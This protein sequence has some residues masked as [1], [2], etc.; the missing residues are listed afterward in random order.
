M[1]LFLENI[2]LKP[3]L[4]WVG[5][6]TQLLKVLTALLPNEPIINYCEPFFGGGAML[7]NIKPFVAF[8]N[9]SNKEL[10][11][12]YNIIKTCPRE[13]IT[14]LSKYENTPEFYY[15]IRSVDRNINEFQ[16]LSPIQRA[17]RFIYLNKTCFNGLYRENSHGQFNVPF[18]KY[19]NPN[20]INETEIFNLAYYFNLSN[21]YFSSYDFEKCIGKIPPNTF[22]YMD[23]PYDPVSKTSN[24]TSYTANSFN[25]IDQIR[26]VSCCNS[27]TQRGIKFMLSNSDT[28][29]IRSI[30]RNYN[31]TEVI[32]RR[33]INCNGNNRG[34]VSELIIRNYDYTNNH[35]RYII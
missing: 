16:K 11:N 34:C 20:F 7:F 28:E 30:Y 35:H 31:I 4:K 14:E 23:P 6:K 32:A 9:D 10:I 25:K 1:P 2:N 3:I 15:K 21:I 19:N 5:G 33:S 8:I 18:G 24:F 29:F 17:A 22:V 12:T 13:L 26:L 27:L